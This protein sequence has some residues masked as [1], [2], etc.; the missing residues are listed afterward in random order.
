MENGSC[1]SSHSINNSFNQA[2]KNSLN[3]SKPDPLKD[4]EDS[5]MTKALS[6]ETIVEQAFVKP[7]KGRKPSLKGTKKT[8]AIKKTEGIASIFKQKEKKPLDNLK[9]QDLGKMKTKLHTERSS[10]DSA[11]P[12]S[13]K[14][15]GAQ[16]EHVPLDSFATPKKPRNSSNKSSDVSS[17][18]KTKDINNSIMKST[19]RKSNTPGRELVKKNHKGETP[20]HV[21]CIKGNV[22]RVRSLLE[23]KATPNTK[24]NAGWTPLVR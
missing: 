17:N 10:T 14:I 20:L 12:D 2:S 9:K 4:K 18:A 13:R 19:P 16:E 11:V 15:T 3:E 7:T 22:A 24:D 21:A 6:S 23:A 5:A 8:V 1:K